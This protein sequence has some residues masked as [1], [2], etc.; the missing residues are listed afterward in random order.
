[1]GGKCRG[2]DAHCC[3]NICEG[4]KPKK[5]E[6][7]KSRC[8]AH[9]QSTCVAGQKEPF[10]GGVEVECETSQGLP[11][12]CNTTTG[13]AGY[14]ADE[15]SCSPCTKDKDCELVLG[16][17]AA[18]IVCLGCDETGGIACVQGQIQV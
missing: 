6:K 13:N 11:G 16:V 10:C 1:V 9:G 2:N 3:S 15:G 14:C 12:A 8:V 7:D 18:C 5:G 17:G 4:S